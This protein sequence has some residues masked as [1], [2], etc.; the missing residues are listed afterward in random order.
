MVLVLVLPVQASE[1][2]MPTKDSDASEG[3]WQEC[4][5]SRCARGAAIMSRDEAAAHPDYAIPAHLFYLSHLIFL[6]S[7]INPAYA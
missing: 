1:A 6:R 7:T 4:Y 5:G 3:F 2:A